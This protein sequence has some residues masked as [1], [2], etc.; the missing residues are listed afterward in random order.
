MIHIQEILKLFTEKTGMAYL[1]GCNENIV[2][3]CP[4]CERDRFFSNRSHG[5][6]NIS[7]M[8]PIYHCFRCES[9]GTTDR[10][11]KEIGDT[12]FKKYLDIEFLKS[13]WKKDYIK[14]LDWNDNT[15]EYIL[16]NK[17][18]Q[19]DKINY[20]KSRL[21]IDS[22]DILNLILDIPEFFK[23]NNIIIPKEKIKLFEYL[24]KSF[25]GFLTTRK[26]QIVF[27]NI[28]T[29]SDFRYYVWKM[30]KK[31][32][33][34]DFYGINT[35]NKI[36]EN[37]IVLCE[38]IFD[39]LSAYNHIALKDIKDKSIFW[40]ATMGNNYNELILS[41]LDYC[42]IPTARVIMLSDSDLKDKEKRYYFLNKNPMVKS[43]TIYYNRYY[44]DFGIK[45]IDLIKENI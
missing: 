42:K 33:F 28:D 43:L 1:D 40:A 6:M 44:K 7:L 4:Y 11:I 12:D 3:L 27:R 18:I 20:L 34:K 32:F 25:I 13:N 37:V 16:N 29:K 9:K 31:I 15:N 36:G 17:E 21:D 23:V 5:H 35:N 30:D 2:T 38:G 26:T 8:T 24:C 45:E 19:E 39:L 14:K 41:V 10:L 22:K